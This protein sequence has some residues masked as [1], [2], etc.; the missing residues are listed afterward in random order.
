MGNFGPLA[1][2]L[3]IIGSNFP[4][5]L[6]IWLAR[7]VFYV[8]QRPVL[9]M[10]SS[11]LYSIFMLFG[12]WLSFKLSMLTP[13]VSLFIMGGAS[14]AGSIPAFVWVRE[15]GGGK[16]SLRDLLK[17]HWNFGKWI[18]AASIFSGAGGQMYVFVTAGMLGLAAAGALRAMSNFFLPMAQAI[19]AIALLGISTLS[20]DYGRR[21]LKSMQVK[22][23]F[24][25]V[26]LTGM[27][28]FY[29]FVLWVGAAPL[30]QWLYGGKYAEYRWLISIL[31]LIPIFMALT[32]GLSLV[33]RAIQKPESYFIVSFATTVASILFGIILTE[34]WHL[35]GAAISMAATYFVGFLVTLWLYRLWFSQKYQEAEG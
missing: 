10:W 20:I 12:L 7:R 14:F 1:E 34:K 24:L 22:G 29:E 26:S 5:L 25:T 23:M 13:F 27:A 18:L 35:G 32:T 9:A 16:F 33:L 15:G 31:G 4:L 8:C 2:A 6:L 17:S 3:L 11:A 28:V 30:E 19:T 21:D